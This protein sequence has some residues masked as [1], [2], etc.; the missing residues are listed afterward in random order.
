MKARLRSRTM[1]IGFPLTYLES[2]SSRGSS[3]WL[4]AEAAAIHIDK[5]ASTNL[6]LQ[7]YLVQSPQVTVAGARRRKYLLLDF[8]PLRF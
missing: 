3:V 2:L 4:Y 5:L 6:S 7:A 8:H 1:R